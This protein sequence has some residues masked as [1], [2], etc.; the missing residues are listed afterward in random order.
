MSSKEFTLFS[1]DKLS[2]RNK[3]YYLMDLLITNQCESR[4]ESVVF[5]LIFYI[6]T[7]SGFFSEKVGV[8]NPNKSK[9]DKI[10][11]VIQKV[12]R[13]RELLITDKKYFETSIIMIL[14]YLLLIT[15]YILFLIHKMDIKTNYN[16]SIMTL[17]FFIKISYYI[18]FNIFN[19]ICLTLL[20][21]RNKNNLFIENYECSISKHLPLFILGTISI[22]YN[23]CLTVFIQCFYREN[24]YLSGNYYSE[25]LTNYHQ[26]IMLNNF[27]FSIMLGIIKN[28]TREFFLF[29]N[30]FSSIGLFIFFINM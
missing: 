11:N 19:D 25:L 17:N 9:S 16:K 13:L 15:V 4:L 14:I 12:V 5:F 20:C 18:L 27:I 24:F 30:F 6:Q 10:L 1:R 7:L 23:F 29:V 28:L 2:I 22:I 21:F 8:V 26:F 3:F